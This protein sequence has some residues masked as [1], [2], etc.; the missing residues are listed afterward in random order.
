MSLVI[1]NRDTAKYQGSSLSLNIY[2]S[3]DAILDKSRLNTPK[4]IIKLSNGSFTSRDPLEGTDELLGTLRIPNVKLNPGQSQKVTVDFTSS[5]LQ[6]P[7]VVAPGA[8]YLIAEISPSTTSHKASE[9]NKVASQFISTGDPVIV[10][11]ATTLNATVAAGKVLRDE[12]GAIIERRI[13]T[14][15]TLVSRNQAIVHAAIYDAVNAITQSHKSLYVNFD[16]C[17]SRV[18]GASLEAAVAGAA[19]TALVN[20]YPDQKATFDEQL[21][22]SLAQ[23]PDGRAERKGLALGRTVAEQILK[24]RSNDGS[25]QAGQVPFKE[26]SNPG[27]WRL[28]PP[29]FGKPVSPGWGLVTPFSHN[30]PA[31]RAGDDPIPRLQQFNLTGPVEFGSKQFVDETNF[32]RQHGGLDNT[33]ATKI[34]RTADQ[35]ESALFWSLDR[36]DTFKPAGQ[37]NE[38]AQELALEKGNTLE[39]NALLFAQLNIAEADAAILTWDA[40]YT[41]N[42]LRPITSIRQEL[43]IDKSDVVQ[44]VDW[45]PLLVDFK[46]EEYGDFPLTP[47][48]PDYYSGHAAYGNAAGQVLINFFGNN[49]PLTLVSQDLPGVSRSYNTI[50]EAIEDNAASR[51][52]GGVHLSSS[53]ITQIPTLGGVDPNLTIY[54]TVFLGGQVADLVSSLF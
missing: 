27:E 34:V 10:W 2:A 8:Y 19:Y 42:Q 37:W 38:I 3:P 40:K 43:P 48:F 17:D 36:P 1:T 11:N 45:K 28:T 14:G 54:P 29:D 53:A 24:L 18:V 52:Y 7:S 9:K 50:L 51:I 41:Y 31:R 20:I 16:A 32:V 39:E 13:G 15:P 26:G 49:T 4:K 6:N 5:D 25:A 35:T 46:P 47:A 30:I 22:R 23:I 33:N 21:S 12:Y 44:D